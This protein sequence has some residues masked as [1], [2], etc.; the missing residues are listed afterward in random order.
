MEYESRSSDE[1][2]DHQEYKVGD[3]RG[4]GT[5]IDDFL[6]VFGSFVVDENR[7]TKSRAMAK[8]PLLLD[9]TSELRTESEDVKYTFREQAQRA[10]NLTNNKSMVE[11]DVTNV[12]SEPAFPD[13]RSRTEDSDSRA[14]INDDEEDFAPDK[15]NE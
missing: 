8:G 13:R 10:S 12:D 15:Q 7:V 6:R 3:K 2:S 14:S 4:F 11:V 1:Q 5:N 9:E